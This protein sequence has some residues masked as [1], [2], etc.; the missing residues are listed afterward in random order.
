MKNLNFLLFFVLIFLLGC[1]SQ[2]FV[3]PKK[4]V[5][6]KIDGEEI[7]L[8]QF[9]SRLEEKGF[10][11]TSP[12]EDQKK[13]KEAL[14]SL[15]TDVLVEMKA[16]K[17]DLSQDDEFVSLKQKHTESFLLDFLY[18]KEIAEKTFVFPEEIDSFYQDHRDEYWEIPE[19]AKTYHILVRVSADSSDSGFS[20]EDRKAQEK[21]SE[22]RKQIEAGEDFFELAKEYSDDITTKHKGGYLG[23]L[24]RGTIIR[25]FD[26]AVFSL[27][28]GGV[29]ELVRTLDGYHLIKVTDVER[30]K[31]RKLDQQLSE[32][33]GDYLK[34]EKE[35]RL[36]SE[37]LDSLR[38]VAN[39][40]FNEEI[41]SQED[42]TVS[43]NPWVMI[44]EDKDTVWFE[45]YLPFGSDWI[46]M[47]KLDYL[48]IEEK[49]KILTEYTD[50]FLSIPLLRN[51]A[52]AKGYH[53]TEEYEKEREAFEL[54]H[55]KKRILNELNI[56]DYEP[57]E[58]EIWDYYLANQM[59]FVGDTL[60]WV[61]HILFSDSIQA[62]MAYRRIQS[63]ADFEQMAKEYSDQDDFDLGYISST[64][65]SRKF[66]EAASKTKINQVSSP[67]RTESGYHLILVLDKKN[68]F[69]SEIHISQ[70]KNELKSE[71]NQRRKTHWEESLREGKEIWINQRLLKKYLLK[72]K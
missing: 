39:L 64:K 20:E 43:G 65:I 11:S 24:K 31:R 56:D 38:R 52:F 72:K 59:R 2:K 53:R 68:N 16:K 4:D 61:R 15:I 23:R 45:N 42:S 7:T 37:Y 57:T 48:T 18:Q 8:D 55:K 63:G 10:Y 51:A 67:V 60:I 22:I 36:A 66:F 33:I 1:S 58:K 71:E 50:Y 3:H 34:K 9:K 30:G 28:P 17:M 62:E 5:I 41:L 26:K 44:I 49:K 40:I 21:I 25:V 54:H 35:K 14:Q 32:S 12:G 6:A 69:P 70:I 47:Q 27:N 13:K 19:F 29:S 46:E